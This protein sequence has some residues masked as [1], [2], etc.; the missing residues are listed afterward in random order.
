MEDKITRVYADISKPLTTNLTAGFE[1]SWERQKF[2]PQ[3]EKVRQYSLAPSFDYILN[4]SITTGHGY[5][6]NDRNSDINATDYRNNIVWLQ[7][8]YDF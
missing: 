2:M 4:R 7:A 6:Y 5:R 8:R 1:V 3:D